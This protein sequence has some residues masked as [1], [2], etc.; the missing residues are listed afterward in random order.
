MDDIVD[1]SFEDMRSKVMLFP[2]GKPIPLVYTT[3]DGK[4]IRVSIEPRVGKSEKR[5][6]IGVAQINELK[7]LPHQFRKRR[8]SPV[9]YESAAAA[10]RPLNLRPGDVVVA[11][12]D[13]DK[14]ND[15]TPLPPSSDKEDFN[16]KALSERVQRRAGKPMTLRVRR[17]GEKETSDK[18]VSLAGFDF[19]DSIIGIT[20]DGP[21]NKPYSPFKV[22]PLT[23]DGIRD[24]SEYSRRIQNLAGKPVVIRVRRFKAPP[25]AE[26]VD[27]FVPP[28]YA[29]TL[30]GVRMK[31][32]S[33]A[34]LR[35]AL[36]PRTRQGCC[37]MMLSPGFS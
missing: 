11:A 31:M 26:P 6:V 12:T 29:C 5:P 8:L 13:P 1:P 15:I 22:K 16:L 32:G 14:D 25:D 28:G 2:G 18:A 34:A 17:Q 4:V 9:Y 10:A 35:T 19:E 36:P 7:L 24:Y 27:L 3:A 20:D 33:V 23:H 37:R 21:D 30:P